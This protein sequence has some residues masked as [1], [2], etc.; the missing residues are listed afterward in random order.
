MWP[1][2][3]T[4]EAPG[5]AAFV[6]EII[7]NAERFPPG[8]VDAMTKRLQFVVAHELT[9]VFDMLR[10]L[11]PAMRNWPSFWRNVLEE[12]QRYEEAASFSKLQGVFVDECGSEN[13]LATV[14]EY[15]PSRADEWFLA[16]RGKGSARRAARHRE[17]DEGLLQKNAEDV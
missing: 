10:L 6:G 11:V 1:Q 13:E 16:L 15:W 5:P 14:K 3:V 7:I 2:R 17:G 9:H 12:G 8:E 4:H